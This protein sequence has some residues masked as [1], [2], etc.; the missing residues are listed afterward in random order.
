M[1][2]K[3][4]AGGVSISGGLQVQVPVVSTPKPH[5]LKNLPVPVVPTYF[6]VLLEDNTALKVERGRKGCSWGLGGGRVER[7]LLDV[8][9][10]QK[11]PGTGRGGHTRSSGPSQAAKVFL[12]DQAEPG[13]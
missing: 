2:Q 12:Q 1:W 4:K 3:A 8:S 7:M 5:P 10:L 13:G 11:L 9:E 6:S